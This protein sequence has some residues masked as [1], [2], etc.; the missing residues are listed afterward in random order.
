MGSELLS[1]GLRAQLR[2]ARAGDVSLVRPLK[3]TRSILKSSR[4]ARESEEPEERYPKGKEA[5]PGVQGS[6]RP[7]KTGPSMAWAVAVW[8]PRQWTE[9]LE[10]EVAVGREV[11]W[12]GKD[13][14]SDQE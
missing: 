4:R 3:E 9:A 6:Q 13:G 12:G 14:K 8:W 7:P 2:N 5:S 11:D 1:D 10:V